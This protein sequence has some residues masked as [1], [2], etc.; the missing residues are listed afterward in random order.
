MRKLQT[1]KR[2]PFDRYNRYLFDRSDRYP[3]DRYRWYPIERYKWY[4]LAAIITVIYL[5]CLSCILL[6]VQALKFHSC[7]FSILQKLV[8]S[9]QIF[10]SIQLFAV[11][12]VRLHAVRIDKFKK[13][14]EWRL[15]FYLNLQWDYSWSAL[16]D[17]CLELLHLNTIWGNQ[18]F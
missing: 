15:Y 12:L 11:V 13:Y 2:Y 10:L 8:K 1:K 18:K 9:L 16:I 7:L 3:F 4:P 5:E 17:S 14:A 6:P